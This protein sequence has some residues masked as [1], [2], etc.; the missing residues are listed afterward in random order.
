M[1]PTD[2]RVT[3]GLSYYHPYV[4][5]L[6]NAAKVIAE[7]LVERGW[8][9][10]VVASQHDEALPRHEVVNGVRVLRT[11]VV[12]RLSKAVISPSLPFACAREIRRT[13][14]GNLHLPFPDA[15]AVAAL[16]GPHADL[17]VT[18]QCDVVLESG[19]AG[20]AVAAALDTSSRV[21][22]ARSRSHIVSSLDYMS[23]SRLAR[24]L[25]SR[26]VEIAPPSVERSAGKPTFRTGEGPHVGFLGRIVEEKGIPYL[27]DAFRSVAAPDWRLLIGGEFMNI[28]GGSRIEEVRQAAE[29]DPRISILGFIPD[30]QLAD[31]YASMDVFAFPSINPLEAFGIAQVEAMFAGV[32][33]VA[34]DL[35]GVRQPVLR[36]GMGALAAPRDSA[37]LGRALLDVTAAPRTRWQASR[38]AALKEYSLPAIVDTWEQLLLTPNGRRRSRSGGP[39]K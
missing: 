27:V 26:A 13:G 8:Q 33:V 10:T 1:Q 12:G 28:A 16:V 15:G 36:T 17:T 31:F 19:A 2:R 34:S 22:L 18:Y 6:T 3:F 39:G 5:G 14:R 9:V 35:P 38:A 11:P 7:Q 29:E 23:S 25:S 37:D 32:P 4:S 30:D 21:A 20:R 24:Q